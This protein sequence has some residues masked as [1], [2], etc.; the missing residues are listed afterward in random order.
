M[1]LLYQNAEQCERGSLLRNLLVQLRLCL[2]GA[3][4]GMISWKIVQGT[5]SRFTEAGILQPHEMRLVTFTMLA[6]S[7][8][9]SREEA[10]SINP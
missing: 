2:W 6:N 1:L 8:F 10:L 9:C 7:D 5:C 4:P 3:P